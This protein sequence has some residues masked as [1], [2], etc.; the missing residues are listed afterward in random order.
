VFWNTSERSVAISLVISVA[1]V[2]PKVV[3]L[4]N[5]PIAGVCLSL[6]RVNSVS[7]GMQKIESEAKLDALMDR[8]SGILRLTNSWSDL[9]L[10]QLVFNPRKVVD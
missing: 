6:A 1:K 4:E 5:E 7:N 8:L 3:R 10:Q 2:V 9:K